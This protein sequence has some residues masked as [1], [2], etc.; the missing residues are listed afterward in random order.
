MIVDLPST[1]TAD[2]SKRLVA[3]RADVGSMGLARV[4]TLVGIVR[5]GVRARG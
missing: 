3:L 4:P 1:T 2:V 5:G